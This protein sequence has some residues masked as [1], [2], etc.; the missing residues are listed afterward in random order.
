MT[1]LKSPILAIHTLFYLLYL[2]KIP[3]EVNSL[4]E[5]VYDQKIV[6]MTSPQEVLRTPLES[7]TLATQIVKP[8]LSN[9]HILST[10]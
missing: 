6:N 1:A 9:L 7:P 3:R 4:P 10:L 8:T 2:R 5:R